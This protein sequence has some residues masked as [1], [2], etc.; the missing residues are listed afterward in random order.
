MPEKMA[1]RK[2]SEHIIKTSNKEYRN[3]MRKASQNFRFIRDT[4][5]VIRDFET[6]D[7]C[8]DSF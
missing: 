1:S 7:M 2:E 6:V 8:R 4:E 3:E 5:D